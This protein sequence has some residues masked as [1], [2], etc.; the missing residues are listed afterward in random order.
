MIKF[1]DLEKQFKEIENELVAAVMGVIRSGRYVLG[2]EVEAFEKEFS[3]YCGAGHGIGVNSGTSALHLALLAAGIGR[4]DEVITT[5]YTFVATVSAVLYAEA[6]PVFVDILP[7]TYT[8]NPR[9]LEAKITKKTKAILPVHLYGQAADMDEINA[10]AKKHNLIVIEDAAQSHGALY[11]GK[12]TGSLGDIGCF[13]FYPS[14]NLGA[15]GEGGMVVTNNEAFAKMTRLLRSWGEEVRYYHKY[16]GFNYRM[17]GIQGAALRVKLKH[18][19]RWN[20]GRQRVAELY[21]KHLSSDNVVLPV[22]GK[23]RTH[24]Y[25]VYVVRCKKSR[26]KIRE[27][28]TKHG[29]EN[30]LHYPVPVHLQEAYNDLGYKKGDLPVAEKT[31]GEVLSLPL[32]PYMTEDD[33]K[34]VAQVIASVK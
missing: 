30:A 27:A 31:A 34:T 4:G 1:A 32:H 8:M 22:V 33:V 21:R 6:K 20:E 2:P 25:H 3:S 18:L 23:D 14:K 24:I 5:P 26:D 19:N 29:I 28:L 17:E 15:C 12:P 10:I 7:D 13:S 11:K 9:Q 16:R